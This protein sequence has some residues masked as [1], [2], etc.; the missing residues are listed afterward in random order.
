MI[1]DGD[2]SGKDETIAVEGGVDKAGEPV[3]QMVFV[4]TCDGIQMSPDQAGDL[5]L[6]LGKAAA[7]ARRLAL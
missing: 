1:I 7:R 3:V 6:A 5:A 2:I 4:R